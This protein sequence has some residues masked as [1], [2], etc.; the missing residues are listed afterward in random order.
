MINSL[1]TVAGLVKAIAMQ[2]L[3]PRERLEY[4]VAYNPLSD[5]VARDSYAV[6]RRLRDKDPVHRMT[7]DDAWVLTRYQ[8]AYAMLR[9]HKIASAPR[10]AASTIP[11]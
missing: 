5:E 1:E 2:A 8:H 9:D 11:G 3:L 4:D 6:Y 7:L 10:I